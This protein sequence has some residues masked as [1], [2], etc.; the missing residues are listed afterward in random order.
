MPAGYDRIGTDTFILSTGRA[1]TGVGSWLPLGGAFSK[2]SL[3]CMKHTTGTTAYTVV[4]Q[5]ALGSS[6]STSLGAAP[7]TLVSYTLA[8]DNGTV[9]ASTG[10]Q[11]VTHISYSVTVLGGTSGPIGK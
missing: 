10:G 7:R 1:T 8:A 11:P 4:L 5:G 9:K 6:L 2:W 3:H